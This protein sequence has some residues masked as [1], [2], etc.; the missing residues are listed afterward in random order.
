[1]AYVQAE[2]IRNLATEIKELHQRVPQFSTQQQE[3]ESMSD[4]VQGVNA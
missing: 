3:A 1:M 4:V 2:K